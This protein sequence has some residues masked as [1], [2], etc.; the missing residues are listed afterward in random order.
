[1]VKRKDGEDQGRGG[2]TTAVLHW[3]LF[4]VELPIDADPGKDDCGVSPQVRYQ[5]CVGEKASLVICYCC[6]R[7]GDRLVT[8]PGDE[9]F[10]SPCFAAHWHSKA[11]WY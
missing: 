10:P 9:N 11:N 8:H 6:G 4:N 5:A 1:M 3:R 7:E 2:P